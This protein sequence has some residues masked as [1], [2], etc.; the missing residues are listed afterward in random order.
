MCPVKIGV[1]VHGEV[2]RRKTSHYVHVVAVIT[3]LCY[4]R[5]CQD[6]AKIILSRY[7]KWIR[8]LGKNHSAPPPTIN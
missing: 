5:E 2:R 3:G 1:L 7:A 6:S 4:S 8:L